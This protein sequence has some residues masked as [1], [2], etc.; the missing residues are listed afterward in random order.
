M[1]SERRRRRT[2]YARAR[3]YSTTPRAPR[4]GA[5]PL[6]KL[7][8]GKIV[9]RSGNRTHTLQIRGPALLPTELCELLL[10][11]HTAK[12]IILK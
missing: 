9:L 2:A 3:I 1:Q 10:V 7:K 8:Y 11:E 12:L 6:K 4:H 5:A